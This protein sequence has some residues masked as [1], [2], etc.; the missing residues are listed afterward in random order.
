MSRVRRSGAR[1]MT[2]CCRSVFLLY[3][4]PVVKATVMVNNWV[5][6]KGVKERQARLHRGVTGK[7]RR[8][9]ASSNGLKSDQESEGSAS[10]YEFV[11]RVHGE[12][13]WVV[14][15]RTLA[16]GELVAKS[17][18]PALRRRLLKARPRP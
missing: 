2:T 14:K 6:R 18:A 11:E 8:V 4:N 12:S 17:V 3:C 10:V 9:H 15:M 5:R 13:E 1:Y 7:T 16:L